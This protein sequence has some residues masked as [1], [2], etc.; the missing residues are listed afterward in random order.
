MASRKAVCTLLFSILA[1]RSPPF[2][3][4][5]LART[6]VR[7]SLSAAIASGSALRRH[8]QTKMTT[9]IAHL[10]VNLGDTLQWEM[11][12]AILEQLAE[13]QYVVTSAPGSKRGATF[14]KRWGVTAKARSFDEGLN[15]MIG[16]MFKNELKAPVGQSKQAKLGKV[17]QR[18]MGKLLKG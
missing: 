1:T 16:G 9:A 15:G 2:F 10:R 14:T 12:D 8:A 4:V 11:A 3:S 18:T 6:K 7:F 17:Y 5:K 13:G